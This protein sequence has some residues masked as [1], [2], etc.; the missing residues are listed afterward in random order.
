MSPA[1]NWRTDLAPYSLGA[2]FGTVADWGL[3][4]HGGGKRGESPGPFC[5][6]GEE[7]G[8]DLWREIGRTIRYAIG[9]DGRTA[10]LIY[11]LIALT[12]LAAVILGLPFQV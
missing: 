12:A 8:S 3:R 11:V 5:C 7:G 4:R 1:A 2:A 6:P 10:R 9:S